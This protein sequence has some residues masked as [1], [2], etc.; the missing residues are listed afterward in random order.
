MDEIQRNLA[1]DEEAWSSVLELCGEGLRSDLKIELDD[2]TPIEK[3]VEARSYTLNHAA[4]QLGIKTATLRYA[5]HELALDSFLD[6]NGTVRYPAYTFEL[7]AN[8]PDMREMI[9]GYERLRSRDLRTILN[10]DSKTMNRKLRQVGITS[11]NVVWRDV[12]GMWDLPETFSEYVVQLERIRKKESKNRRE[13]KRKKR[14]RRRKRREEQTQLRNRLIDAFPKWRDMERYEQKIYMHIGDPN[15]G[16]TYE[17]LQALKAS[18]S[19][20]Y[21]APLRLLAYEIYDRLNA[22]GVACNLLT[23][24]EYIPVEGALITA[25]TIEMFNPVDSG[26]CVIIDEAQMLADSDRGWAWTRAMME[27]KAPEMHIIGPPTARKLMEV[28]AAAAEIPYEVIEHQRLTPIKVA[29][30]HYTLETLPRHTILVAFTRQGVLDLK[31]K[32]ERLERSVSVVYGSLPP[33]VRRR[34]ADRFAFGETEICVAT[35][36]VGMGLNLPADVVCFYEIEKFDGKSV[37]RLLPTEV[38]QIGGRAGRYGLSKAGL[39]TTTNKHHLKAIRELHRQEPEVL[40]HARV[41]PTVDDLSLIPGNL[42]EQ[43]TQW[44]DL[45]SIPEE[46]RA[47]IRTADLAERV[48]LAKMLSDEQIEQIGLAAALQLVNAPTRK[49]TRPYWLQC[50][51]MILEG[52]QIPEPPT[53]SLPIEDSE[54]LESTEFSITCADI[55]LWLSRRKEFSMYCDAYEEIREAR[56]EWSLAIDEALLQKLDTAKRCTTCG[57]ILPSRHRYRICDSCYY[58]KQF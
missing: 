52:Y 42:S 44:A 16:K 55:Y 45:E 37:R 17:A 27:C 4:Q 31:T 14:D 53:P 26:Q 10:V 19:G 40:T 25:A 41:A 33:E 36:A 39:I 9:A 29:D 43:L 8:D 35:D 51:Y 22:D 23:G 46:L 12:R 30:R 3:Q 6:P 20:W 38:R 56:R 18:G 5:T 47:V 1:I 7:T 48:E 24:E 21:L 34:Q 13:Q 28:L 58:D 50:A 2:N 15:S 54:D 11:K 57:K 49:S 32:L